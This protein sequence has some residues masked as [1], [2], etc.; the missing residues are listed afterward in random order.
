MSSK[1]VQLLSCRGTAYRKQKALGAIIRIILPYFPYYNITVN[2]LLQL[3]N[4]GGIYDVVKLDYRRDAP[5]A[6]AVHS[7]IERA[8]FWSGG[9]L[10]TNST[11]IWRVI[12]CLDGKFSA[13][14]LRTKFR[15]IKRLPVGRYYILVAKNKY[16]PSVE[17]I[18]DKPETKTYS[19]SV[20][21][22]NDFFD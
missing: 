7:Q 13:R 4:A 5:D 15:H 19:V 12:T 6:A 2:R 17:Y 11:A 14:Q 22:Q 20:A 10:H 9:V 18:P 16:L 21:N 1:P 8:I 3:H